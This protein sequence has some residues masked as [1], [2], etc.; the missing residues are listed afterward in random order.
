VDTKDRDARAGGGRSVTEALAR[1]ASDP[2]SRSRL[3]PEALSP[4]AWKRLRED[5]F[6][7]LRLEALLAE[8]EALLSEGGAIPELPFSSFMRFYRDGDRVEYEDLYF[9]RRR[10]L[11]LFG[12]AALASPGPSGESY[13]RA[14]E[15]CL[16]A[17]CGEYSWCLP[18]HLEPPPTGAGAPSAPG[19]P[20]E[21]PPADRFIDLFSAETAFSLAELLGLLGDR[22][23]PEAANR[24]EREVRARTIDGLL[25]GGYR[26]DWERARH[27]WAAVCSCGVGGA[28][29]WL[30]D[31]PAEL[32]SLLSRLGPALDSYLEGF[33]ADGSCLE[34][35]GYWTYGF[36]YFTAFSELLRERSS[37][38]IDLLGLPALAQK[39]GEIA[40]FPQRCR[41]V[42]EAALCFSD[43]TPPFR[44]PLGIL[45][46]LSSRV[47]GV[48]VPDFRLSEELGYDHCR[49]WA[50]AVRDFAWFDPL[51]PSLEAAEAGKS[52]KAWLPDAQ[53][54]IAR[55]PGSRPPLAFAAKG[56]HNDEPHNHNDLGS[57]VLAFG[58]ESYLDDFG[59][60]RYDRGY[61]GSGRYDRFV[62][63]SFGHSVPVV[64]GR[65]QSAGRESSCRAASFSPR[66]AGLECSFEIGAAYAAPGLESLERRFDFDP[67]RAAILAIEDRYSFALPG[68]REI[69]ERFVSLLPARMEGPGEVS[70]AGKAGVL[71][72]RAARGDTEP[73]ARVELS[74]TSFEAH[75]GSPKKASV[76]DFVYGV[77]DPRAILRFECSFSPGV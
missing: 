10:R 35:L 6:G 47:P 64:D 11:Q 43:S 15:D 42:G 69:R 3:F 56:G 52:G 23:A 62:T 45:C 26:Y 58:D 67:S 18:A 39:L 44:Y 2:A 19:V 17:I 24:V 37:G 68:R 33:A 66:E 29:L 30:L 28:A 12:L 40:R 72:L 41:L 54:A 14:L 22:L 53:W 4:A 76:I 75:R 36:G 31:D 51:A 5:A 73:E 25:S 55:A 61:F 16:W 74:E 38:E 7:R 63:S 59:A 13:L 70:I 32:S 57:F 71:R 27:N 8:A 50:K 48:L 20:V 21:I 34:G 46:R 65:G 60:G 1:W 9:E 77:E 49:R